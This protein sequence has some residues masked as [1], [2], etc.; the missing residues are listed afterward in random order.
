MVSPPP[1]PSAPPTGFDREGAR[2]GLRGIQDA[3]LVGLLGQILIWVSVGAL[4]I[5][6]SVYSS[7]PV[8]TTI[9]YGAGGISISAGE[10]FGINFLLILGTVVA[11]YSLLLCAR[12]FRRLDKT[13]ARPR[14]AGASAL[15]TVG[16]IGL[17]LF[18]IAWAIWLGSFVAPGTGNPPSVAGFYTPVLA[19]SLSVTLGLLLVVGGILAFL[20]ML[21]IAIGSSTVGITYEEPSIEL[22]GILSVLPGLSIVSNIL[23]IVGLSHVDRKLAEGW[24]PPPPPP[25]QIL[26]YPNP[27]YPAGPAA[28]PYYAPPSPQSSWDGLAVVLVVILLLVWL[29]IIPFAFVLVTE[30]GLTKGPSAGPGGNESPPASGASPIGSTTILP[31]LIVGVILT[32]LLL[33]IAFVRNRRKR[34]KAARPLPPPPPP[35]PPPPATPEADPLDHLV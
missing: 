26:I 31:L 17:G 10:I 8:K 18:A 15:A 22:G 29:I 11:L 21:G 32:G 16:S 14:F 25:P 28:G 35:P 7:V 4:W 9:A 1:V 34:E 2:K 12:A 23:L 3:F 19:T 20:G 27:G 6:G 13:S 24:V 30:E 5:L 33:P